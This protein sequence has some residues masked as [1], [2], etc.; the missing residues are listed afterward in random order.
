MCNKQKSR[1]KQNN[2]VPKIVFTPN[3]ISRRCSV[4]LFVLIDLMALYYGIVNWSSISEAILIETINI[5]FTVVLAIV[6]L[7]I[8]VFQSDKELLVK[9][10]SDENIKKVYLSYVFSIFPIILELTLGYLVALIF[11][12]VPQLI[13]LYF[14]ITVLVLMKCISGT[15]AA[16]VAFL[17]I[18]D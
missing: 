13:S 16:F 15:I 14:V 4:V 8:T 9:R 17:N 7:A 5:G 12:E 6:A 2:S 10:N 3:K 1:N 11:K 18:R